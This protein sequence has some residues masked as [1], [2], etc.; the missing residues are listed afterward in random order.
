[1]SEKFLY[2]MDPIT[3]IDPKK[4]TTFVL[5]LESQKRGV[6]NYYCQISDLM[7]S[8]GQ[9]QVAAQFAEV[10]SP[11]RNQGHVRLAAKSFHALNDFRVVWMRK[12]P[13]VDRDF[14]V[15]TMLLDLHDPA[16]TLMMNNSRGLRLA[17]EKLWG[18]FASD[19][20]PPTVVAAN[21]QFLLEWCRG[22]GKVVLKPIFG[23]GGA[24]I[25]VFDRD[26]RNLPSAIDL[27]TN[28]GQQAITVQQ[29]I[30]RARE[31]DKRVLLLGGEPI[32]AVLR[33]PHFGDHR[34][35][36]HVGGQVQKAEIDEN[37]RRIAAI[38]KPKL[39]DLG[40]HLVGLDIIDQK[41]TE[42]NV[43]SPTGAQEIDALDHRNSSNSVATL[44]MD[45]VEDLISVAKSHKII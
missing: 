35:N 5:M 33:V 27:L 12:D 18:L 25:M 17:N 10:F 29:F 41:L 11:L 42:I 34:A 40:L 30:P 19:L 44:V 31:G 15:A 3:D 4:D 43:T 9:V 6:N 14:L 32:G 22:L 2:I 1:M 20:M 37:D 23:A 16:R 26:D 13:P 24:G 45:Y 36:I 21:P 28:Y 8:S 7:W 38:L 39:L